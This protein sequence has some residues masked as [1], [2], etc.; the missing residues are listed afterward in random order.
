MS[1][2]RAAL[3]NQRYEPRDRVDERRDLRQLGTDME[4]DP[5]QLE[6][7]VTRA[8]QRDRFLLR[9]AEFVLLEPRRDV[10]MRLRIDVGVDANRDRRTLAELAGDA[11]EQA[12]LFGALDVETAD[13]C[14]ERGLHL[15]FGL[16]DAGKHDVLG[17][18]A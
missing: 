12:E 15:G 8:K 18:A 17:R 3:V 11:I 14:F 9:Y 4:V 10:R 1:E 16:A 7:R 2:L 5:D 13:P 6:M